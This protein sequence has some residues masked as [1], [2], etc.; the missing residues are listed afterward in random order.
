MLFGEISTLTKIA[1]PQIA[2]ITNIGTSHIGELGSKEN[3]LKAKL[4]I[5]EGLN[6]QGTLVINNDNDM[7]N[8]W[9]KTNNTYKV[10]T[11]GIEKNSQ[12]KANNIQLE[13][14]SSSFII[15]N[16][17]EE[18]K[19]K[20]PV[21][22]I[23]F[24]YNA[25]CAISVGKLLNI[26]NN[27]ILEGIKEF[28][29]TKNRMDV[30]KNNRITIINDC[31]NAN[32]D[33]MSA[34]IKYLSQ[35]KAKRKIAVLGDMLNLG[36]YSKN[37]HEKIGEEIAQHEID[38]LI[39]VG[40]EVKH[41]IEKAIELGINKQ[42]VYNFEK[43]KEAIQLLKDILKPEDAILVKASNAMKFNEIVEAIQ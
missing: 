21:G 15:N 2:V 34:A 37:L 42:N 4:E 6:K 30:K 5:L 29:L 40:K 8:K 13:E 18:I 25:L 11:F 16:N 28:K 22:G 12:I 41:T 3:I 23:H 7:L 36:E 27:D 24:V 20:V 31:Y 14:Y 19:V 38:I 43:N 10:I 1:K 26:Q 9:N 33:S 39:T 32:Y 17:N 35:I